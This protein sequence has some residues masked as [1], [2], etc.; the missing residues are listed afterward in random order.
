MSRALTATRGG[1]GGVDG[2][3]LTVGSGSGA[4]SAR[5]GGWKAPAAATVA[6]RP[7]TTAIA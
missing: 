2:E 1:G 5:L 6:I 4:G 3:A 7:P